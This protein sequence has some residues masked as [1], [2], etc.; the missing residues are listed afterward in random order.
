[1]LPEHLQPAK[2]EDAPRGWTICRVCNGQ[3]ILPPHGEACV[4]AVYGRHPGFMKKKKITR[5]REVW[6]K[7]EDG[8]L[9]YR[10]GAYRKEVFPEKKEY[11]PVKFSGLP[12]SMECPACESE[13]GTSSDML[14][15]R[16]K[17]YCKSCDL[18][19]RDLSDNVVAYRAPTIEMIEELL[20]AGLQF[21]ELSK[22]ELG[23]IFDAY[24]KLK[25][26]YVKARPQ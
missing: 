10:N 13:Y 23:V 22:G 24:Q 9:R 14:S 8:T 11:P 3:K 1:M 5:E 6:Y 20:G 12:Y 26:Q 21:S 4:C 2:E 19:F 17:G 7:F 25:E 15:I 16:E 18:Y